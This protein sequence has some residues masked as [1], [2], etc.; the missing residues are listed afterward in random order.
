[1]ALQEISYVTDILQ[2]EVQVELNDAQQEITKQIRD[3]AALS[4]QKIGN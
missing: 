2:R 3:D 4:K 1:M